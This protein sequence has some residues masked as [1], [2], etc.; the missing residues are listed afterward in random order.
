MMGFHDHPMAAET[1]MPPWMKT[2]MKEG[3]DRDAR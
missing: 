1:A 2:K 3:K